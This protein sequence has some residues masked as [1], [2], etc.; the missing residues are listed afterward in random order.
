MDSS[1]KEMAK[2]L[3]AKMRAKEDQL[4]MAVE[5]KLF[6]KLEPLSDKGRELGPLSEWFLPGVC[7][8]LVMCEILRRQIERGIEAMAEAE[9]DE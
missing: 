3:A 9:D 1:M 5:K 4:Y 2:A 7:A 8:H 6:D